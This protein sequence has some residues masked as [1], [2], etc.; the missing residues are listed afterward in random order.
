VNASS[1]QGGSPVLRQIVSA[2]L[3]FR[4]LVVVGAAAIL[5]VGATQVR[6]APVEVLPDFTPTTV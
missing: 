3:R 6:K 4:L 1:K 2:S 5:V